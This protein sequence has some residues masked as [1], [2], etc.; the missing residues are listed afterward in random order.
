MR[1][2]SCYGKLQFQD[3]LAIDTNTHPSGD[4]RMG[5]RV[6]AP[7]TNYGCLFGDRRTT[8]YAGEAG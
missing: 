5:T 7:M 6:I 3:G 8:I 2:F 1:V 4:R